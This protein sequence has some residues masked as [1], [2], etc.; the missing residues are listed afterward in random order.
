M[1]RRQA[2]FVVVQSLPLQQRNPR[3]KGRELGESGSPEQRVCG[4]G[5]RVYPEKILTLGRRGRAIQRRKVL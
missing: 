3:A 1:E 4:P 5:V 2:L